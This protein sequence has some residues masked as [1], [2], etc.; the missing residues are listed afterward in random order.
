MPKVPV[1]KKGEVLNLKGEV[2][3]QWR[4][5]PYFFS[6]CG[7]VKRTFSY[8]ERLVEPFNKKSP[9]NK[10]RKSVSIGDRAY[11]VARIVYELFVGEIPKGYVVHHKDNCYF[12]NDYMN[13]E[14][15]TF[16]EEGNKV[17]KRT[18]RS[19]KVYCL[20]KGKYYKSATEA[21]KDLYITS[22][23]IGQICNG[24]TKNPSVRVQWV[25]EN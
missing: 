16:K 9:N 11:T 6:N 17:G 25:K 7:R 24:K 19:K 20:D 13:L 22:N 18:R 15:L 3:K 5:T 8:G 10:I 12:N 14:V 21:G 4:D 2:W 23:A 1:A